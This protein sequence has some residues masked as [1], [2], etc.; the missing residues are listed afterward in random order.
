MPLQSLLC[1]SVRAEQIVLVLSR[2]EWA[3]AELPGWLEELD[4]EILWSERD[5]SSYLK[6]VELLD[7]PGPVV[8]ADDDT[9]YPDSWLVGLLDAAGRYP[10]SVVGYRGLEVRAGQRYVDWPHA[11]LATRSAAL[12]LTGVGGVLYPPGA[13]SRQA[14]DVELARALCPSNDDVWFHAMRVLAGTP[15]HTVSERFIEFPQVRGSQGDWSLMAQNVDTGETDRQFKA[16]WDHFGLWE[17]LD[18]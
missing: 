10:G 17:S 6:L 12:H 18:G 5:G 15:A 2:A 7:S 1:Q 8:T 13:L 3:D 4:L 9:L 11:T 16:V 14:G